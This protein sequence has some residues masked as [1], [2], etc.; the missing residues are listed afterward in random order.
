MP[1]VN[2][3][4]GCDPYVEIRIQKGDP[5]KKD[6]GIGSLGKDTVRT[7]AKDGDMAPNWNENLTLNKA[8]HGKEHFVNII[9]WDSN[10]TR[11]TPIGY[12]AICTT[13]LLASLTYDPSKEDLPTKDHV[14]KFTSLLSDKS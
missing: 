14:A 5:A 11:N 3:F 13:D 6:G 7:T 10:I 12:Q 1:S 4:G 2:T 9:L 8:T